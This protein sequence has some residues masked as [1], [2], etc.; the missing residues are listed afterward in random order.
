MGVSIN[1]NRNR[2]RNKNKNIN[3]NVN[4]DVI[5]KADIL[6]TILDINA[7]VLPI[8]SRKANLILKLLQNIYK[9]NLNQVDIHTL[10]YNPSINKLRAWSHDNANI[11]HCSIL[12]TLQ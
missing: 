6:T 3:T 11:F 4:V 1:R 5:F 7:L 2:N 8:Y 12:I 10:Q 9:I